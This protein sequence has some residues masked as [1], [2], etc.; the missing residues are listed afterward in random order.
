MLLLDR[1]IARECL[2]LLLLA[3]TAFVGIYVVVD[4]FE[5]FTKFLEAKVAPASILSYYAFSLPTILI[6]VMP[7][8]VLLA[9][10]LAL[11]TMARHNEL[12]AMKMGQLAALRI[13][14][15]GILVGL[16][17]S[18]L[19]WVVA[20]HVA[21]RTSEHALQ[22]WRTQVRKLPAHSVTRDSDIW[23]RAEGERFVHISLIEVQSGLI[24]GMSVFDLSPDFDLLTRVD[25]REAVWSG[26]RWTLRNGYQMDLSARSTTVQPFKELSVEMQEGPQEF[27]RVARSP[28]E[29]SYAQLKRYIDR[30]V[31][32]GVS[33][34][35]YKVDL[36]AKVATALVS[37]IMA[38]LGVS[39]GLRTGRAGVMVWVGACIPMGFLYWML[40]SLGIA[41]GRGG[42][43]PPLV[44]AWLPNLAFGS[45]GLFSLWRLRG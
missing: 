26:E 29:M 20:E 44:A 27:A 14:L 23:Y 12:L 37:L 19:A 5:K 18:G 38:V 45:A 34:T 36:H 40:L 39:F 43:V 4:L 1:Y 21:P 30:L 15:P 28:Q 25:A 31:A 7:I 16:A 3:L 2:K 42:A 32:S 13:A 33:A 35:R 6:Q 11:G 17:A 22:I 41:L 9:T 8:A 24:R 10:L